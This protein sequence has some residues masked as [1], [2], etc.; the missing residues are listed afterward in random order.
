MQLEDSAFCNNSYWQAIYY[1]AASTPSCRTPTQ[2]SLKILLRLPRDKF[3]NVSTVR[4][5]ANLLHVRPSVRRHMSASPT[6]Q[7]SVKI[8]SGGQRENIAIKSKFPEVGRKYWKLYIYS[9]VA[10]IVS[11]DTYRYRFPL[12]NGSGIN[13]VFYPKVCK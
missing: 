1:T 3:M 12:F 10:F 6:G 7:I 13:F 8:Y 2:S 9:L 11:F 4:I 5:K